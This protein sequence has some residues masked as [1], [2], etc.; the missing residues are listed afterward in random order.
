MDPSQWFDFDTFDL[1]QVI[2]LATTHPARNNACLPVEDWLPAQISVEHG[3]SGQGLSQFKRRQPLNKA[4]IVPF[5][6]LA[7]FAKV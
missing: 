7:C 3:H 1:S 2:H 5:G 6:I 4:L